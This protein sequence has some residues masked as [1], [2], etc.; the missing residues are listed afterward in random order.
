LAAEVG[1]DK[2]AQALL[3]GHSNASKYHSVID[4]D[5]SQK[6]IMTRLAQGQNEELQYVRDKFYNGELYP[7]SAPKSTLK[8]PSPTIE[9]LTAQQR[10]HRIER[11]LRRVV[12]KAIENSYPATKVMQTLEQF[13]MSA[14]TACEGEETYDDPDWKDILVE[15]PTITRLAPNNKLI[16]RFLFDKDSQTGG[17]NR[18][19]LHALVQFHSLVATSATTSKGRMLT[20]TGSSIDKQFQLV[21]CIMKEQQTPSSTSS[22]TVGLGET[23]SRI[24]ALKV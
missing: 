8:K 4:N 1:S 24:A 17:F 6:S 15:P 14:F 3:N 21:D 13:L 19:L 22:S 2:A 20:A 10:M 18:L 9:M 5:K 23:T 11:R 12:V 7:S 16:I